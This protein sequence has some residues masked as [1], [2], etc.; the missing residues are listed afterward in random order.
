MSCAGASVPARPPLAQVTFE[1]DRPD[2]RFVAPDGFF[3][4]QRGH[5]VALTARERIP[6]AY[7]NRDVVA[8]GGLTSYGTDLADAF[9]QVGIYTGRILNGEK[10]SDLPVLQSTN[11]PLI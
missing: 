1:G 11:S 3:Y 6:A 4:E 8:A 2:A 10:P 9:R 7:Q 5:L